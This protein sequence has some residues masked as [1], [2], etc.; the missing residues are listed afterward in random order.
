MS[1]ITIIGNKSFAIAATILYARNV[2][3][4]LD[5]YINSELDG[6]DNR[7]D[8]ADIFEDF[9]EYYYQ[10]REDIIENCKREINNIGFKKLDK[11]NLNQFIF[12]SVFNDY[13]ILND[14]GNYRLTL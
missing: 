5:E 2:M 10:T 9:E 6:F 8:R 1:N 13:D 12:T 7:M 3:N 11:N 14:G 4:Q